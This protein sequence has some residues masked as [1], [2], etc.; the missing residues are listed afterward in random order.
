MIQSI[1]AIAGT[2]MLSAATSFQSIA[3]SPTKDQWQAL[4]G[5]GKV[6]L[7]RHAIAPGTGDP[8]GFRLGDCSTQRNLSEAGREQA[9]QAGQ[10]FR[11]RQIPVKQ[12]HSS[13]WCRCLETARLLNLGEAKTTP[14]LNSFFSDR[15]TADTQTEQTRQ[16]I[17]AHRQQ[18]GVVIMVTHQV[19]ITALTGIVAQSGAAVIVQA[20]DKGKIEVIGELEP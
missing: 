8:S 13:Q 1:V 14:A 5:R 11:R 3:Q 16:I 6:V 10:E 20:N 7:L 17:A 19:N 2:M 18:E 9:R 12:I 4:T 15:R